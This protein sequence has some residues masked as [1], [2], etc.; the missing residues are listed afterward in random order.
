CAPCPLPGKRAACGTEPPARPD[1]QAGLPG[2]QLRV[3]AALLQPTP[4]ATGPPLCQKGHRTQ[5]LSARTLPAGP[6]LCRPRPSRPVS[7]LSAGVPAGERAGG[8][9]GDAA[10]AVPDGPREYSYPSG[11]RANPAG[12]G[13]ARDGGAV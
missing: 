2:G 5:A 9:P 6:A 8:T 12:A 4:L 7:P 3:S 1:A 11:S 13:R 10:K